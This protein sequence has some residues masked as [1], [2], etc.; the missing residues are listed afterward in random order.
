MAD[1]LRVDTDLV[2]ATGL[3]TV[4]VQGHVTETFQHFP[5]GDGVFAVVAVGIDGHLAAVAGA[6]PDVAL[7]GA[8]V[9][10]EVAPNQGI[11]TAVDAVYEELVGQHG[12]CGLVLGHDHQ[13]C[14]VLV[15]AV[16]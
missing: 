6:T 15:D 12:L 3:Q 8:F 11:V 5:V 13:A 10:L 9:F 2:G 7:D 16:D 4:F 1:V 14:G